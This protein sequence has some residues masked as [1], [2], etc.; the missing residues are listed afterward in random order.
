MLNFFRSSSVLEGISYLLILCVSFGIVSREYVFFLGIMHGVL[1]M[2]YFV[3]SLIVSH[4]Q[5]WSVVIWLLVFLAA[6]VPFAF[7]LVEIFIRK[8]VLKSE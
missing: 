1:F 6:I 3:L 2:L 5:S 4:K 8:E 7:L